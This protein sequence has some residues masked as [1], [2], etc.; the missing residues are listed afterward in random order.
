M[1]QYTQCLIEKGWTNK[2]NYCFSL[3]FD[4]ER[5]EDSPLGTFLILS[6]GEEN[7]T[8]NQAFQN[9]LQQQAGPVI[10]PIFN[11]YTTFNRAGVT[12]IPLGT[13]IETIY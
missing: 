8:Y 4:F 2:L 5:W 7:T 6:K 10:Y 12:Y 3:G 11:D 9:L 1:K 13:Y